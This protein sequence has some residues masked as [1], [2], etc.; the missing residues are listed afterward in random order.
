MKLRYV[1]VSVVVVV[2]CWNKSIKE[3]V[4]SIA[5]GVDKSIATE[6]YYN[7]QS[8]INYYVG[9]DNWEQANKLVPVRDS[10]K[11]IIKK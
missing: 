10:L 6:Q 2:L 8:Q 9:I 4:N 1:L 11:A 3:N 5:K 7:V